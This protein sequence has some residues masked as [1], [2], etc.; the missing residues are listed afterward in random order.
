MCGETSQLIRRL[1]QI[2]SRIKGI[3]LRG[4][5][6]REVVKTNHHP[7]DSIV[8]GGPAA[9]LEQHA[10]SS[11]ELSLNSSSWNPELK[12][13]VKML[14]TRIKEIATAVIGNSVW[15]SARNEP[16]KMGRPKKVA[17]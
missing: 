8:I 14:E 1:I 3:A 17:S 16:S 11:R 10:W 6:M 5:S 15:P 9:G 12:T 13:A 2:L 4:D 7:R